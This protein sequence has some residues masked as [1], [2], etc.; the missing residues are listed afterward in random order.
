[1]EEEGLTIEPLAGDPRER[2][3]ALAEVATEELEPPQ[4]RDRVVQVAWNRRRRAFEHG[5]PEVGC[6]VV[7]AS[8][9]V[10]QREMPL[11]MVP[12][13]A[14]M[15]ARLDGRRQS[16]DARVERRHLVERV[17]EG[18]DRPGVARVLPVGHER[19]ADRFVA[20]AGLLEDERVHPEHE[21]VARIVAGRGVGERQHVRELPLPEPDEVE[22]LE[23]QEVPRVVRE[24]RSHRDRRVVALAL[25]E[26]GETFDVATLPIGL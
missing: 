18:V 8:P 17:G 15:G 2:L 7:V 5:P 10:H 6:H 25:H 13:P 11:E 19:H 14:Q 20:A 16:R 4:E 23:H 9:H 3:P 22:A 26:E 12:E 1:M 24:M 21:R